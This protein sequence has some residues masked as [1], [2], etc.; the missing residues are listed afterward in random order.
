MNKVFNI[1]KIVLEDSRLTYLDKTVFTA[2]ITFNGNNKIFPSISEIGNRIKCN[3]KNNISVSIKKLK[4][5]NYIEV[6]RRFQKSNIYILDTENF[7]S[8][9]YFLSIKQSILYLSY[10]SFCLLDFRPLTA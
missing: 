9:V 8:G 4:E 10:E 7:I 2:L 1:L 5:L 3:S 6:K